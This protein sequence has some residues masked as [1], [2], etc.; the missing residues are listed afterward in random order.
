MYLNNTIPECQNSCTN[1]DYETSYN[2][3]LHFGLNYYYLEEGNITA[4]QLALTTQGPVQ[5]KFTVYEDFPY[6][7]EG[8]L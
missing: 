8:I 7:K 6:Y 1:L 2:D 5:V 4:I 3:D